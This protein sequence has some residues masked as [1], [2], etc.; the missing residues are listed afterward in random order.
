MPV[1]PLSPGTDPGSA[2]TTWTREA[3]DTVGSSEPES[4]L[5]LL[6]LTGPREVPYA[7]PNHLGA[8]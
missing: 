6:L 5:A 7:R 2:G 3:T 1:R 8:G 4:I